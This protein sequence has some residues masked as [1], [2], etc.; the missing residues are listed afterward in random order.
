MFEWIKK[1]FKEKV[2]DARAFMGVDWP[3]AHIDS[4]RSVAKPNKERLIDEYKGFAYICSNY[5]ARIVFSTPLKLYRRLDKGEKCRWKTRKLKQKQYNYL[6]KANR[7]NLATGERIEEVI[8]HPA[9]QLLKHP[10]P[11]MSGLKFLEFNQLYQEMTGQSAWRVVYGSFAGERIPVQIYMLQPQYLQVED[12]PKTGFPMFYWY[13]GKNPMKLEL[14]EVITFTLPNL[15]YPYLTG[16][17]PLLGVFENA[18]IL[19][20]YLATEAAI[21]S[22]EGRPDIMVS[23]KDGMGDIERFEKKFITKF[24]RGGKSGIMIAEDDITVT[25]LSWSPKD[26]AF[27]KVGEQA[28]DM[29]ALAYDIPPALLSGDGA[30]QYNVDNTLANRHVIN[31]INPRLERNTDVLNHHYLPLFD[32]SGLL[33]FAYDDP[34]VVN[35]EQ[36][37]DTDC[38]LVASNVLTPNE[39]RIERGYEPTTWGEV[40][41]GMYNA[42]EG[43]PDS[44]DGDSAPD[45]DSTDEAASA[46]EIQESGL[47]GAQIEGLLQIVEAITSGALTPEAGKILIGQAFP[48]FDPAKV[49]VLVAEMKKAK[50]IAPPPAPEAQTSPLEA[51]AKAVPGQGK[52]KTHSE[53]CKAHNANMKPKGQGEL[54]KVLKGFFAKQKKEVLAGLKTKAKANGLPA[55]FVAHKDW[56]KELYQKSQPLIEVTAHDAYGKQAKELQAR[57]GISPD[58]FNVKN[59]HLEKKVNQLALAFCEETNRATSEELN[60]ALDDLKESFE[61]GLSEGERFSQ[62]VDRVASVFDRAETERAELI[63]STESTR[64]YLAGNVQSAKDSGVVTGA[65]VLLSSEPCPLCEEIAAQGEKDL[66]TCWHTDESAPEAY[67]DKPYPPFH[68]GCFCDLEYVIE[69]D[70]GE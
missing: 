53:A 50:P 28:R 38:R 54:E 66:D 36:Q 57:S 11:Q 13:G 23:A 10:N 62:L 2:V 19:D 68:P 6:E 22:N 29:I 35:K 1:Y 18:N 17:A 67:Q 65:K 45:H 61:E 27:V 56:D 60:K 26:L 12:D 16:M 34:S 7:I 24:R 47:N 25:P 33:F 69:G 20:L 40:P 39:I 42:T 63:A 48:L 8:N 46:G 43:Q 9:L 52:A 4:F 49:D 70:K 51:P 15:K 44:A 58:V 21:L 5:N 37:L 32:D 59:P 64:A 55:K 14:D 41:A 3:G 30:T 31:A